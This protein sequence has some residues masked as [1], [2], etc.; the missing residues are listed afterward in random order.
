MDR[1]LG[2]QTV[3]ADLARLMRTA[4]RAGLALGCIDPEET[5]LVLPG[6]EIASAWT[7]GR[8]GAWAITGALAVA[9]L[10]L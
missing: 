7:F 9:F 8:I 5:R 2:F 6:D 3:E 1:V 10:V 4:E